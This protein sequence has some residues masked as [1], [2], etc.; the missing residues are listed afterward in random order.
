VII[1]VG[2][3]KGGAGKSTTAA[4]LAARR[5]ADGYDVLLVDGDDQETTTLW[6]ATRQEHHH[7]DGTKHL[8][9]V[10]L[11]GKAAR[12]EVLKL[13]PRY[14]DVVIDVGGRDTTTQRAALTAAHLFLHPLPPRGPDVWTLD[15]VSEL[16]EE[17]RTVNPE[18]K[19]WAFLNRADP[20]GHDNEDATTLIRETPG[21]ELII[22]RLGDRKAFP[23]AHTQ[24]LAVFELRGRVESHTGAIRFSIRRIAAM[25]IKVSEVCTRCS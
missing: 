18:L 5:A 2:G 19:A 14:R 25:E 16:V 13:A 7:P 23:N 4:N 24:G 11:R 12:S 6:S 15:K 17:V 8:T 20:V 21:L 10:Q 1:V 22:P 3:I 9:C